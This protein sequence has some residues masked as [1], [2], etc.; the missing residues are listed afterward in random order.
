MPSG[1]GKKP[2]R[3][4]SKP[5][6]NEHYVKEKKKAH[7]GWISRK[8]AEVLIH[9][10]RRDVTHVMCQVEAGGELP[11]AGDLEA[12]CEH[13]RWARKVADRD[14]LCYPLPPAVDVS[15]TRA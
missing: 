6:V 9:P 14:G 4:L 8:V 13:C 15:L 10:L 3:G 7:A 11:T 1:D 5:G 12:V 2:G